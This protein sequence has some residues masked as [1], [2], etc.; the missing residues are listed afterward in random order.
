MLRRLERSSDFRQFSFVFA[1][2]LPLAIRTRRDEPC[3]ER[4][5][6]LKRKLQDIQQG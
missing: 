2:K 3:D 5:S 1:G 6:S 4:G